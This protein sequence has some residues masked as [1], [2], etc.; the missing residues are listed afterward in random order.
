MGSLFKAGGWLIRTLFYLAVF[1][2]PVLGVWLASSLVAYINGPT[3]L[4]VCSGILLFPLIPILWDLRGRKQRQTGILTWRDRITLRTLVLNLTFI[5]LLLALRPQTS[6]LALST[7]GDWFLDGRQ[8]PHIEFARQGL[9]HLARGLEGIYLQFHHNPFDQ[10][11]DTTGAQPRPRPSPTVRAGQTQGWPWLDT[12]L[13]PAV[14]NMPASVETSIASVAQYIAQQEKDPFLRVKAL[15][16]YVADRIAYDAP[17]YFAGQYPPQDAE[18]VFQRRVAVCA[19]YAKLLEALGQAI[20]EEIV[21]VTGDSRSSTSD[22]E[23]QSHAWNAAKIK[24]QWYLIDTTWDSGSV[25]R[26]SGFTKRYRADYLFPPPE[27]MGITHFPEDTAWQLRSQPISRGEFLRQPI[28]RPQ[29]FAEGLKLITPVRSQ[30]DTTGPATLQIQNPKQRWL[31]TSYAAKGAKESQRCSDTAIQ[32][33]QI[34]CPLPRTG[35]YEI[36]LFS[37]D[38]QYGDFAYVGQVEFNKR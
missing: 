11:A 7:R 22:L 37:G 21:Y 18:T 13:H 26:S 31:L 30:T 14:A 12:G 3:M 8:G 6:F 25:D 35:T 32:G 36:R 29:F 33:P 38:E 23:G 27:V 24:G 2:T 4:A 16:D 17:A 34:T 20:G 19:G 15:H 10:Y 1:L 5:A 9:F 28:L